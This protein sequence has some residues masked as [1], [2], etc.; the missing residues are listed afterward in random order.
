[1]EPTP[2]MLLLSVL[3]VD[4]CV[5]TA[6]SLAELLRFWG[7]ATW[8]AANGAEALRLFETY[9]PDVVILDI[10]MPGMNGWELARRLR[11]G[12]KPPLLVAVTGCGQEEDRHRSDESGIHLHLI[13]PVDPAVLVAVLRRFDRVLTPAACEPL[14]PSQSR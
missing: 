3:I 10:R 12:P 4:D 5:D 8:T 1:M 7:C 6:T 11:S 14:R 9:L 13:K 2:E